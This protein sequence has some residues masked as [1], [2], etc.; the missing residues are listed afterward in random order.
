MQTLTKKCGRCEKTNMEQIKIRLK[1][2]S[3]VLMTTEMSQPLPNQLEL[4]K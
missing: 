3:M 1:W 2:G 4:R